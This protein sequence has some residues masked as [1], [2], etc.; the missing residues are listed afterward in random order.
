MLKLKLKHLAF[1]A[2]SLVTVSCANTFTT[3]T[4]NLDETK[5]DVNVAPIENTVKTHLIIKSKPFSMKGKTFKLNHAKFTDSAYLLKGYNAKEQLNAMAVSIGRIDNRCLLITNSHVTDGLT[6]IYLSRWNNINRADKPFSAKVVVRYPAIDVALILAEK[7]CSNYASINLTSLTMDNSNKLII[8]VNYKGIGLLKYGTF[9][10]LM[11]ISD[12][13]TPKEKVLIVD[14]L[15]TIGSSGAPI[16]N[17]NQ[18]LIGIQSAIMNEDKSNA[19]VIPIG[20]ITKRLEHDGY[21][22]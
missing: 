2:L 5:L 1:T 6:E 16:F 3:T 9:K 21:I 18:Q 20:L 11:G 10:G 17:H 15:L 7:E 14:S 12:I 4:G 8:P 13:G 22:Q 19:I